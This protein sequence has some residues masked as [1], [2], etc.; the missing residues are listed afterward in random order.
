MGGW[1]LWGL[2]GWLAGVALQLQQRELPPPLAH[3]AAAALALLLLGLLAGGRRARRSAAGTALLFAAAALSAWA[4]T[5]WRAGE[6]LAQALDPALEGVDLQLTGVVASLPQPGPSGVRFH[7]EVESAQRA[8]AAVRVPPRVSLGW[9]R[10]WGEDAGAAGPMDALRAGERWRFTVRLRRPQGLFNPHGFDHE[11]W[12][13]EQGLRASGYVRASPRS[14][15]QRLSDRAGQPVDRL[16]QQ[17]RDAIFAQV[18]QSRAA[19]VLAA[20]AVGDQGAIEREDWEVF[21]VTGVAHLMAISGLHVTMFAWLGAALL[22]R[23]WRL[24]A[25]LMLALPAPVAARWGGLLLAAGYALLAGWGVPAQRTVAMLAVVTAVAQLGRRWPWPLALLLAAACVLAFDPWALLQ[26]GFWLSFVAVALLMASDGAQDWGAAVGA[27]LPGGPADTRLHQAGARLLALAASGLHT[28]WRATLGL[29]PLTLL[30]FRQVSLVGLLA[31]L[32]AIPVVT[33]LVTPLALLGVLL[34]PLWNVAALGVEALTAGLEL[35][36]GWPMAQWLT[37]AAPPWAVLAGL[38]G[39]ALAVL[40]LPQRLRLLALPLMLPLLWPPVPRPAPGEFELLAADVGQGSAVLV[41]TAR[42]TLLFDAGPRYS[43]GS[44]AGQRV[45][46]PL[47]RAL[48]ERRLDVLM[49]SHRDSDHAGGAAAVLAAWPHAALHGTLEPRHPLLDGRVQQPC[50]AG[51][52]WEWDGVRFELLHP[53]EGQRSPPLAP[54]QVSCVLRVS[55]ERHAALLPGDIEAA[56]ELAL[57]R[58]AAPSLRADWLLL[59]HHGSRTSSSAAWL[60]AVRPRVAVVQA[61]YRNRFGHP[62]REVLERLRAR[63]VPVVE[64]S[65][66]GAYRWS[67]GQGRCERER[68]RRYW[69]HSGAAVPATGGTGLEVAL[70]AGVESEP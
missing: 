53:A 21:R 49:L 60:D 13:F 19:G 2:L 40:P 10:G 69:H 12:L 25:R 18:P 47:L 7:F 64:T 41:R 62:S 23:L 46:V 56:Q 17:V 57:V 52:H 63:G 67:A 20:L 31:N 9:Y 70:Q 48:G 42:H 26:P 39:G 59:A 3:A 15:A 68:A 37:A 27:V 8:G 14:P 44:D 22:R 35:L 61:G 16:R 11:L 24:D 36:A 28:Q 58:S 51:R 6:R 1:W 50:V 43:P 54:N 65:S 66:C 45:L 5:G 4:L 29:A 38:A 33:L 30:F 55:N 34:P 32:V